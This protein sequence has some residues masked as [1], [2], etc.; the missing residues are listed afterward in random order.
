MDRVRAVRLRARRSVAAVLAVVGRRAVG[1]V[2]LQLAALG[3]LVAWAW[4]RYGT[5]GA[6]FSGFA[7]L[8]FLGFVVAQPGEPAAAPAPDEGE[9]SWTF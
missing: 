6:L 4:H 9:V 8:L 7:V 1:A 5:D 2:V 3:F